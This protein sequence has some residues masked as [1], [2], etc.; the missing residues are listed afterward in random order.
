MAYGDVSYSWVNSGSTAASANTGHRLF[1]AYN[2]LSNLNSL[3]VVHVQLLA[4][5]NDFRVGPAGSVT[6]NSGFK[7]L[8]SAWSDLPPITAGAVDGFHFTNDTLGSNASPAWVVWRR[9][10]L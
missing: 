5:T 2:G 10:P 9:N 8:T 4:I 3:E 1:G 6:N 7:V